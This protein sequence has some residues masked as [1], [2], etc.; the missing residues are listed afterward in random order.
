[1]F[2]AQPSEP[3]ESDVRQPDGGATGS[4]A[5]AGSLVPALAVPAN[6]L[7]LIGLRWALARMVPAAALNPDDLDAR[8]VIA[9]PDGPEAEAIDRIQALEAL[10]SAC[11]AAQARETAAL[12]AH[13]TT[14]EAAQG[15]PEARRGR[16]LPGEVG[17]ARR[18]GSRGSR[19]LRLAT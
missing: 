4:A 19:H 17:L 12:H 3:S 15:I 8:Q 13:R 14:T 9:S 10:K 1:M 7:H 18:T 2:E 16:G 11:A 5:A 6:A